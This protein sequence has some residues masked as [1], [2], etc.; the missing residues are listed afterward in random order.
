MNEAVFDLNAPEVDIDMSD[1]VGINGND[2]CFT[3][4]AFN[5][6]SESDPSDAACAAV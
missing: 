4:K 1:L 6:S 3:V 2:V 5:D